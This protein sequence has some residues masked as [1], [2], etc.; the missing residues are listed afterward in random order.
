M[1]RTAFDL[2]IAPQ[3]VAFQD[4]YP[5]VRLEIAVEARLVDIVREG[6]DAGFRTG[7]RIDKEMVAAPAYLAARNTPALPGDLLDHRAILCRS[8]AI[9][10]I[11]PWMLQSADEIAQVNPPAATVIHDLASQVDLAVRALGIVS[12][13][14]ALVAD[15]LAQGRLARVLP[16]WSSPIEALYLYFPSRRQQ[17]AAL[18][19]FVRFLTSAYGAAATLPK[20][21]RALRSVSSDLDGVAAARL[22]RPLA[23]A[24]SLSGPGLCFG[25]VSVLEAPAWQ[26]P[27]ATAA[28]SMSM[29]SYMTGTSSVSRICLMMRV[30]RG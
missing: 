10:V 2:L 28:P 11:M 13:P 8:Q 1:A 17:S 14:T 27:K 16:A 18:R 15:L 29:A 22:D 7:N 25:R 3:L 5:D 26:S 30:G 6:F 12:L 24:G 9:V 20:R 23:Q 4:R 19:A 21:H